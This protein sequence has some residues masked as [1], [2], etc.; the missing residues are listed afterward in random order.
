MSRPEELPGGITHLLSLEDG[1]VLEQGLKGTVLE[2]VYH[3]SER[4][5]RNAEGGPGRQNSVG[6][7]RVRGTRRAFPF[8]VPQSAFPIPGPTSPLIEIRKAS[9]SYKEKQV[10]VDVSWEVN[11]GEHWAVMGPNGSG[12][13][14]LLSLVLG[15]NP[16]AY[17]ND[18]S[19]F[20]RRR[21]SGE[22]V[23]EI[24]SRIGWVSSELLTYYEDDRLTCEQVVCSGFYDSIGLFRD[25]SQSQ[26]SAARSWVDRLGLT[27]LL[28]KPFRGTSAGEKRLLLLA[29]ALVKSPEMLI[30]D[31]PCLGLD[32]RHRALVLELTE[33]LCRTI[34][35]SLIYVTHDPE[36]IGPW[37]THMLRLR[38]GRVEECGLRRKDE[39]RGHNT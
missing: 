8:R 14:T 39:F 32:S 27:S 38:G 24:K 10:L 35:G 36:E 20:G 33:R 21:G 7:M 5:V 31:E 4:G 30:L 23:W 22:T 28:T 3:R 15:D 25:C 34:S 19:L 37:I 17:E 16:Q 29:R 18:I 2:H 26:V 6:G 13:S 12:K 9:I 11:A 1:R